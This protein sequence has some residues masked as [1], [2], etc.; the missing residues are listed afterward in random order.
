MPKLI[1]VAF[2]LVF[3]HALAIAQP[4]SKTITHQKMIW[5]RYAQR[6]IFNDK[7]SV[8]GEIE[9]RRFAAPDK[10]HQWLVP[11]L[12]LFYKTKNKIDFGLSNALFLHTLPQN[13]F[14]AERLRPEIRPHQEMSLHQGLGKNKITH[15]YIVEER[16]LHKTAQG[17]LVSGWDF[18]LRFRYRI[19]IQIPIVSEDKRIPVHLRLYDEIFINSSPEVVY[20][21]FDHNRLYAGFSFTFSDQ[22]SS[23]IGY[24]NWFQ[25]Q[26]SGQDFFD[27]HILRITLSHSIEI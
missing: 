1:L 27:R 7:W 25:Q 11:R 16:F 9:T 5:A 14:S 6:L 2:L 13:E 19:Q 8:Y 10:Q 15:R 17:A 12:T 20:N 23:E 26:P 4:A 21:V 24:I 18:R 3:F 22:W